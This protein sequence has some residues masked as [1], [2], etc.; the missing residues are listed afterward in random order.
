MRGAHGHAPDMNAFQW[1][2]PADAGSTWYHLLYILDNKDHPRGCGEHLLELLGHLPEQG[3]PP[4]MRGAQS[5][6][7]GVSVAQGIIPADA[8]STITRPSRPKR[9]SDHPRGCGEHQSTQVTGR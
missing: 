1:I 3:S 7:P 8:G 5:A 2:I 6:G 4:R 9:E